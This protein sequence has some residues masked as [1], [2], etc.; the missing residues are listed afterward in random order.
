MPAIFRASWCWLLWAI[1]PAAAFA[2][3][4]DHYLIGTSVGSVTPTEATL[5]R[6]EY[7]L[8]GYGTWTARGTATGVHDTLSTRAI[9]VERDIGLCLVIIDSLGVPGPIARRIRTIASFQ[10]GLSPEQILVAA[11]HTHAAPDLLGLWG[12]A[13]DDYTRQLVSE[14]VAVL[15][16]AWNGRVP[17]RLFHAVSTFDAFNRRGWEG[18]A[19]ELHS[20][21][22]RDPEDTTTLAVLVIGGVH[23]TVSPADNRHISSDFVHYLREQLTE[24]QQAPALFA[25]G[26]L[27]DVTPG[28]KGDDYWQGAEA[29]GREIAESMLASVMTAREITAPITL[30]RASVELPVDN[31]VLGLAQT[32][33]ILDGSVEGW[34]WDQRVNTS[35]TYLGFGNQLSVLALPGEP[36]TRFGETIKARLP[37]SAGRR[38]VLGQVNDSLG[39]FVSP[40]EWEKGRNNN[41]EE[42]VSLGPNTASLLEEA[43]DKAINAAR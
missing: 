18:D 35:V 29:F 24:S 10:T 14:T 26:L 17:S 34:F 22:V 41:Y 25:N 31:F 6:E 12:G 20:L 23:P 37:A 21:I 11:T 15:T 9:C 3:T 39:Y 4:A 33:G 36:L 7:F 1:L 42:S 32:L 5:A 8:G 2:E 43:V 40:D 19:R 38:I 13:P 16:S 28:V 27:G 30:T